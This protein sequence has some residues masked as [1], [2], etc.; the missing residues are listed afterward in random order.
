VPPAQIAAAHD[1][2]EEDFADANVLKR[3]GTRGLELNE[4]ADGGPPMPPGLKDD[5]KSPWLEKYV[6]E[7]DVS[8]DL[9]KK[10]AASGSPQLVPHVD[11]ALPPGN[12]IDDAPVPPTQIS[13]VHDE[14]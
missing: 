9:K 8:H 13:A 5:T 3:K 1:G 14:F 6:D 10:A 12:E 2:F 4:E 7:E 11:L